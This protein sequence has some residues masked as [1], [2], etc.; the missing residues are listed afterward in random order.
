[1][2]ITINDKLIPTLERLAANRLKTPEQYINDYVEN[3]L[4]SQYKQELYQEIDKQKIDDIPAIE[5]GIR[6][7]V[8]E[9]KTRDGIALTPI[10]ESLDI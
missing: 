10:E 6:T 4:T 2:N 1:M 3:H 9:F 7:K 8:V 5:I